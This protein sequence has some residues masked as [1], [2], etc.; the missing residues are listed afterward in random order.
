MQQTVDSQRQPAICHEVYFFT[1]TEITG[2]R[3]ERL[4]EGTEPEPDSDTGTG[5]GTAWPIVVCALQSEP[6]CASVRRLGRVCGHT[7]YNSNNKNINNSSPDVPYASVDEA[8]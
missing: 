2:G 3:G 1:P 6:A 8:L 4:K 5:T 7:N